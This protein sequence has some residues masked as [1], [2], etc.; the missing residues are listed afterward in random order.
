MNTADVDVGIMTEILN[1]ILGVFEAGAGAMGGW[2]VGLLS[3]LVAIEITWAGL[4]WAFLDADQALKAFLKKMVYVGVFTFI[5]LNWPAI[6]TAILEGF[7]GAGE[8][9]GGGFSMGQMRDPSGIVQD[10]MLATQ[11]IWEDVADVSFMDGG[12]FTS[13]L[14][15]ILGLVIVALFWVLGIQIFMAV[16]EFYIVAA[17]GVLFIPWGVNKHTKW[18]SERYF[19]AILAQ[20]TKLMVLS[21]LLGVMMPLVDALKLTEG[22]TFGEAVSATVGIATMAFVTWRAPAV[23]AGLMS[24]AASLELGDAIM[25]GSS[26]KSSAGAAAKPAAQAAGSGGKTALKAVGAAALG[27][28]VGAYD[29]VSSLGGSGGG[30]GADVSATESASSGGGQM[31][32][33]SGVSSSSVGGADGSL[34]SSG[35][36]DVGA[37]QAVSDEMVDQGGELGQPEAGSGHVGGFDAVDDAGGNDWSAGDAADVDMDWSDIDL[38]E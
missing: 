30:A 35:D 21:A 34:S 31:D 17:F 22:P 32:G 14:L 28:A 19:G 25:V 13:I 37:H 18:I 6:A 4:M 29:K 3:T 23:A 2:G 15:M 8:Q 12:I 33:A 5:V 11:P 26:A 10:G 9:V 16:V 20:G 38:Q 27:G 1:A 7:Y 36:G 24:G